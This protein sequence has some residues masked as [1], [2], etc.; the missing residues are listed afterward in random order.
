[1]TSID[2]SVHPEGSDPRDHTRGLMLIA[3]QAHLVYPITADEEVRA[4]CR[5][6]WEALDSRLADSSRS[7]LIAV[8]KDFMDD[9][10]DLAESW[11]EE[12]G[13]A[14]QVVGDLMNLM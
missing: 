12:T 4:F 9:T 8:I 13:D 1:M 6:L 3:I 10:C 5:N 2:L 11:A 14:Y 7:E